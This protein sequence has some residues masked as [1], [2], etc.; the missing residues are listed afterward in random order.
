[1]V[2][3]GMILKGGREGGGGLIDIVTAVRANIDLRIKAI[4]LKLRYCSWV[5]INF[6]YHRLK[7]TG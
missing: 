2:S 6:F 7:P 4:L 1:M 3:I 5:K